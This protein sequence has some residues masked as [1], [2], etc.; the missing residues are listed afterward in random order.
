MTAERLQAKADTLVLQEELV[1]VKLRAAVERSANQE[2]REQLK[3]LHT[4][5]PSASPEHCIHDSDAISASGAP[6][7]EVGDLGVGLESSSTPTPLHQAQSLLERSRQLVFGGAGQQTA[8]GSGSSS[9]DGRALQQQQGSPSRNSQIEHRDATHHTHSHSA[10][11]S[12]SSSA[13]GRFWHRLRAN[14]SG[15]RSS[16]FSRTTNEHSSEVIAA[17]EVRPTVDFTHS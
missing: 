17:E 5:S 6:S 2:L 12:S 1:S 10:A 16:K 14:E 9:H 4:P 8:S 7:A 11:S 15:G 3:L 13:V